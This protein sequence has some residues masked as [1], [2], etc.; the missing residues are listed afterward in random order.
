MRG[1][2]L[3]NAEQCLTA[4]VAERPEIADVVIE[5]GGLWHLRKI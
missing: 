2:L 3:A 5:L 4:I 1:S